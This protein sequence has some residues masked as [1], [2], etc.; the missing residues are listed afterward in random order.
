MVVLSSYHVV[1]VK[2][3]TKTA[4]KAQKHTKVVVLRILVL[5]FVWCFQMPRM[6]FFLNLLGVIYVCG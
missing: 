4:R 5:M 2:S 3:H 1:L 6:C